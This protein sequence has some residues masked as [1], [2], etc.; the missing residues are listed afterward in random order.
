MGMTINVAFD[1]ATAQM[2][3]QHY[4]HGV[5]C[6]VHEEVN[7]VLQELHIGLRHAYVIQ[8]KHTLRGGS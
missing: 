7:K 4:L 8:C 6:V 2:P 3:W 1:Q 5:G